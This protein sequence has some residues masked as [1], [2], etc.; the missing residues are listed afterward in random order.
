[1]YSCLNAFQVKHVRPQ[2]AWYVNRKDHN[3]QVLDRTRLRQSRLSLYEQPAQVLQWDLSTELSPKHNLVFRRR[4]FS[5]SRPI[6]RLPQ[7]L[8]VLVISLFLMQVSPDPAQNRPERCRCGC[9]RLFCCW[10]SPLELME[11]KWRTQVNLKVTL[12]LSGQAFFSVGSVVHNQG[13][14]K[15]IPCKPN[16][17]LLKLTK[18]TGI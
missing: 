15:D 8:R 6:Q 13:L 12:E 18:Q 7:D 5:N 1:M 9:I 3:K 11:G 16:T 10:P 17:M 4:P 2:T 14:E